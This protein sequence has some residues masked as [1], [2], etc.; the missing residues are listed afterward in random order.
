MACSC[1]PCGEPPAAAVSAHVGLRPVGGE[2]GREGGPLGTAFPCNSTGGEGGRPTACPLRSCRPCR[3][4]HPT[5]DL[6]GCGSL[7]SLWRSFAQPLGRIR[8]KFG[9][10]RD[11]K[12]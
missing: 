7:W 3:S 4:C 10:V 8:A 12:P 11:P 1:N 2:G 5:K 9:L 6:N